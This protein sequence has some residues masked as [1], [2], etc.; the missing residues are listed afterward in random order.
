[1]FKK[2]TIAA[3]LGVVSTNA[4]V[5]YVLQGK[6]LDKD[7]KIPTW[8]EVCELVDKNGDQS[9]TL[10]EFREALKS[11]NMSEEETEFLS[12]SFLMVDS[13][14]SDSIEQKEFEKAKENYAFILNGTTLYYLIKNAQ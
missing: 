6:K 12:E 13:D 2:L 14:Y 3:L 10:E 7:Q 1:M 9:I 11:L 8:D 5:E 4:D